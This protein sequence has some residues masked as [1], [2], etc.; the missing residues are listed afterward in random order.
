[1]I[2][3]VGVK[4]D[5]MRIAK[6]HLVAA[7]VLIAAGGES[8][9]QDLENGQRLAERW[10]VECH[11]IGTP[12]PKTSRIISF[13]SIAERPGITSDMISS[14]LLMPHATMPNLP[15]SKKDAQDLAA[16]IMKMKKP[17]AQN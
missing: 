2:H 9:A 14:F 6:L 12:T 7:T 17:P 10:C 3:M 8:R 1:M 11:A 15:L 16:F 4:G 13:A 5:G